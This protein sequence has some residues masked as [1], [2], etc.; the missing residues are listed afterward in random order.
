MD[1]GNEETMEYIKLRIK[2]TTM[3][4]IYYTLMIR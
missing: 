2:S 1:E 4:G 3:R